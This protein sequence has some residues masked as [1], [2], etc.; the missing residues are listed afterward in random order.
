LLLARR[1]G[2][3]ALGIAALAASAACL[4]YLPPKPQLR[5]GTFEITAIDVGQG[6]SL[7]LITPEGKTLLLDAGGMP[8]NVR[9]DFDVGE[10]VVSPYLWSRGIRR[11][12]AVAISHAHADHMGGMKSIIANFRPRELWYGVESPSRGFIEVE[13]TA[14]AYQVGLVPHASGDAFDFG[15]VHV[16][17][18]NP[19]PGWEPRDPAQDDESLVLR[20]QYGETSALLVGDAHKRIEKLLTGEH[21]QADLLKVGHHGSATSSSPEFLDAV[22]PRYAVVSVGFYNSFGHPRQEVMERYAEANV[23]TYRTDLAGAVTFLLDGQRVTATRV[24]R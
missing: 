4:V 11:L 3:A 24:P 17:V 21:P 16:R 1:R 13:E 9:T 20:M 12:D 7:L 2:V 6:D 15:G 23:T 14:R 18:L 5:S 10:E 8:G 19:Q 22:K